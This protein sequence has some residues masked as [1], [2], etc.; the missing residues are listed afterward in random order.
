MSWRQITIL[1]CI[2]FPDVIMIYKYCM[3]IF[4]EF[5]IKQ[6]YTSNIEDFGILNI[7]VKWNHVISTKISRFAWQYLK[8]T[9]M[10]ITF[11]QWWSTCLPLLTSMNCL[12][13]R[14]TWVHPGFS[15]VRVNRSLVLYV[16]FVDRCL[17]FCTFLFGHG[18]VCS[19]FI[20]GF[21][22]FLSYLQTLLTKRTITCRLKKLN[23]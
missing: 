20:C 21:W 22:L 15:G 7:H 6:M 18:V 10:K 9:F 14:S 5:I 12:P 19:Y 3:K 2:C 4:M 17:F 23:T 8:Y 1:T 16:Y 11:K 13:F